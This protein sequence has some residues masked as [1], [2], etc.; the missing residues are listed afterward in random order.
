MPGI[1]VGLAKV[2]LVTPWVGDVHDLFDAVLWEFEI[3]VDVESAV[4]QAN[5][6]A[7]SLII[8]MG[9]HP[10]R[11]G[12]YIQLVSFHCHLFGEGWLVSFGAR[13]RG[14]GGKRPDRASMRVGG[15]AGFPAQA[16]L[17]ADEM[18]VRAAG[19]VSHR[20]D[21]FWICFS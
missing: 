8:R 5:G 19:A 12:Q 16:D 10:D 14:N 2:I 18:T 13:H 4:N 11:R 7:F 21:S 6:D 15:T 1:F 3:L 20:M 9:I 17:A